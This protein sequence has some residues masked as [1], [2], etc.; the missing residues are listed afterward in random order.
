MTIEDIKSTL[1]ELVDSAWE[2][3]CHHSEQDYE[4]LLSGI[5]SIK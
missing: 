1:R 3:D 2:N 4:D 5:E